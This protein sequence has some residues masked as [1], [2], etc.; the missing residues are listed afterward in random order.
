M[1]FEKAISLADLAKLTG[2]RVIG[3]GS[4]QVH[5]IN[6]IHKV[7]PGDITFV[8]HPKYYGK[9]LQ[10]DATF[11]IINQ[12]VEA[13]QGKA[14]IYSEFPFDTYNLIVKHHRSFQPSAQ[15]VSNQAKIGEGTV[16]QPGTFVGNN[17]VIGK[18]CIIHSNVSIY[19]HTV[20]GDNVVI[21]ANSVLGADA[22]YFKRKSTGYD[23]MLSCGRVII[24]DD[25]E[26]G[27][28]CT[29]DKGVSG[30]TVIGAGTKLDNQVHVGHDTV[31]GKNC[32]FAGQ[33]GIAGVVTIEDDVIL[34]GQVGVQKDLTIGKG[35]VV[36]GQSGIPKSLEG[37]KTYFGSPTQDARE[38][39]KELAMIKQL[40][41]IIEKLKSN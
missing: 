7:E 35:A 22:F 18:N 41:S 27:A 38:K 17:V 3:D 6:E 26:I 31:I 28:C 2:T 39:M 12:E 23:K 16:I 4:M 15:A 30:D 13:P 20:I 10:S 21:H 40:P 29:I 25:V 32:L 36:L 8:D 11:V 1:K 34:W 9:A 33:V 14:L 37:G 19:D 24:G 5:G